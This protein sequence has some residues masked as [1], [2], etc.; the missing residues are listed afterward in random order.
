MKV[1]V[2]DTYV[3]RKDGAI[4]HFDILVPDTE[5]DYAKV[6]EYGKAYL[7]TKGQASR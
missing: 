3:T 7:A 5:N 6:H 4:M 2:F 1:S